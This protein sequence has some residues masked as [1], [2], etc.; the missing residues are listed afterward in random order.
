MKGKYMKNW[1]DEGEAKLA[2][3]LKKIETHPL[4]T[5]IRQDEAAGTLTQRQQAAGK[6]EALRKE[7]SE[8]GARLQS[9]SAEK[10]A[11]FLKAK[12]AME[13]A[14][15]AFNQA[16]AALR[17]ENTD[18]DREISIQSEILIESADPAIDEAI[19]FFRVKLDELR[20]PGRI[21]SR[22]R[23]AERNIFSMTK[24]IS[25][26][27]NKDEI[28]GALDYCM[29]AI[30]ALEVMKLE[31]ELNVQ[32]IEKM[33]AEIPSIDNYSEFTSVKPLPKVCA[34]L[35]RKSESQENWV[36]SPYH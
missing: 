14:G 30:K 27:S 6:I 28:L 1:R 33:K 2:K 36:M 15:A 25:V 11:E 22:G 24:K 13:A 9:I 23:T 5:K 26:E 18:F 4:T 10:E 16:R 34:E 7:Q 31:P 29:A 21:D 32:G 17:A 35:P 20:K 12:A 19:D 8:T 3:L